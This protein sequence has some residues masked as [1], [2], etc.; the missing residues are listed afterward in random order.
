MYFLCANL[1]VTNSDKN[2]QK[3]KIIFSHQ[4]IDEVRKKK[5]RLLSFKNALLNDFERVDRIMS[6]RIFKPDTPN[7]YDI[8]NDMYVVTKDNIDYYYFEGEFIPVS[9]N[10]HIDDEHINLTDRSLISMNKIQDEHNR[11]KFKI[12]Y[13]KMDELEIQ[14]TINDIDSL[15]YIKVRDYVNPFVAYRKKGNG[16]TGYWDKKYDQFYVKRGDGTKYTYSIDDVEFYIPID[17]FYNIHWE[18]NEY[19]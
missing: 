4:S 14:N 6:H 17:D 1:F 16:L 10:T 11:M 19:E 12:Y 5:L 15:Y 8:T 18:F 7:F 9:I 3:G 13:S 2:I